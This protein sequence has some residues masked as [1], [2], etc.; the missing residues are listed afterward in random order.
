MLSAFATQQ[1]VVGAMRIYRSLPLPYLATQR[2][3]LKRVQK[4]DD[5]TGVLLIGILSESPLGFSV[6][7]AP[8]NGHFFDP[9]APY[10]RKRY[11]FA[12]NG[13]YDLYDVVKAQS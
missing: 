8:A 2:T 6:L 7:Y 1:F 3:Q 12:E 5:A 13:E 9:N 10:G 11:C 4:S